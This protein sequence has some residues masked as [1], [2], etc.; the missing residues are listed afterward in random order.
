M[1]W[2]LSVP[3]WPYFTHL[4]KLSIKKQKVGN[5]VQTAIIGMAIL[6]DCLEYLLNIL[7]TYLPA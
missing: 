3:K 5:F 6:S 7:A 1:F 4:V 2:V